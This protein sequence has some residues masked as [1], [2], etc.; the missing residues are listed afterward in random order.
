MRFLEYLKL[1]ESPLIDDKYGRQAEYPKYIKND[2]LEEY[3]KTKLVETIGN[4]E[5]RTSK[6]SDGK[7]VYSL[8]YIVDKSPVAILKYIF[9]KDKF[10]TNIKFPIV[11]WIYVDKN[12]RGSGI[13]DKLHEFVMNRFGGFISDKWLSNS[14]FKFYKKFSEKYH[15]YKIKNDTKH[16]DIPEERLPQEVDL[17]NYKP[18]ENERFVFSKTKLKTVDL[19]NFWKIYYDN[20]FNELSELLE[21]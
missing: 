16:K 14:S 13:I 7:K 18:N 9:L 1:N 5:F 21:K 4:I 12:F 11:A 3:N 20:L 17:D 8:Y 15:I 19:E 2:F 10:P 6:E